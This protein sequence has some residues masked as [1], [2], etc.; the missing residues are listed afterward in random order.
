MEDKKQTSIPAH[1]VAILVLP[2]NV[3][4]IIPALLLYFFK[5]SIGWGLNVP[6]M[7][8]AILLGILILLSGLVLL[9]LTII[10]FATEGKETLAPW[11]SPKKLAVAGP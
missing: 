6:I 10:Q 8:L 9:V 7:I 3:T 2:F 5:Y 11:D 1:L 4:V